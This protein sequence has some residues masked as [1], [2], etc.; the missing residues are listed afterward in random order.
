MEVQ[1]DPPRKQHYVFAH[2]AL[3][4][5][6]FGDPEGVVR[7]LDG[8]QSREF[9]RDF[10]AFVGKQAVPMDDRF[11]PDDLHRVK[12]EPKAH[13]DYLIYIIV[14]PR[15]EGHVEAHYVC[16]TALAPGGLAM[17]TA[18]PAVRYF[19]LERAA[20]AGRTVLCEWSNDPLRHISFGDGPAA[21]DL[22][23]FANA[24]ERQLGEG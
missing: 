8:D 22:R 20:E 23:A 6:L 16:I 1:A 15:A 12:V 4:A 14:M 9:L 2:Q 13:S 5:L 18:P 11:A 10:W 17:L 19:T 24:V 3:P 21:D 7:A